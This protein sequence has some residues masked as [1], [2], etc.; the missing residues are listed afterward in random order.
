MFALDCWN[1]ICMYV[2]TTKASAIILISFP[3]RD[4]QPWARAAPYCSA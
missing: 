3:I 4:T 2:Y 1:K